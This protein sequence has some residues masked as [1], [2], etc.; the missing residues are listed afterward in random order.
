MVIGQKRVMS[1]CDCGKV[2]SRD[3]RT[4]LTCH[5]KR[6]QECYDRARAIVVIG[7]CP[8]CGTKLVRNNALLGWW[9]CGCYGTWKL[10]TGNIG[11]P[12]C[13]FQTFTG[14]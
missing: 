10:T 12:D 13:G 8:E 5:K 9:Q 11:R 2:K 7:L 1:R 6:M 14:E 4:C 3:S